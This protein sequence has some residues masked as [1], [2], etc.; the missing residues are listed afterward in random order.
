MRRVTA[1]PPQSI[2]E[3]CL[4]RLG[5]QSRSLSAWWLA[6]GLRR[7]IEAASR[8]AIRQNAGLLCSEFVRFDRHH[9]GFI[10]YWKSFEAMEAWSRRPPHS[11]WWR[12]AVERMRAKRDLG[13]YHE[14]Y[15]VR[16]DDIESIYMEC[17]PTGLATFGE[18]GEPIG[19]MTTARGRL[20]R[21]RN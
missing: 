1:R 2:G 13:V 6:R 3:L 20:G 15:I 21:S 9:F 14:T 17:P 4:V 7:Q 12:D 11:D 8:E 16:R 10:Q 18:Q 19:P 5:V